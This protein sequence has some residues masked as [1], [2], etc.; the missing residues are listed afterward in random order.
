MHRDTH[1]HEAGHDHDHD[2]CHDHC[3]GHHGEEGGHHHHGGVPEPRRGSRGI[4]L[5][6]FG[7][8]LP[9]AHAHY[10]L[11][12]AEVRERYPDTEVRWAFTANRIR[13][14]LRDR[15]IKRLSV[16]EA[17]SRMIDDGF[18]H[19]AV[20]SLHTLPSVEYE[21]TVRQAEAMRHPRKGLTGISVGAPLLHSMDDLKRAA[22]V[23]GESLLPECGPKDGV[24]LVGHGTY[25]QGQA[26]YLALESLL[27]QDFQ[28]VA[29]G[30]LMDG[31]QAAELGGR[32]L[33]KGVKRVFLVPF[34]CVPGHHV[35]V[36][37]FGDH[38]HSW[39]SVLAA[40]GLEVS[41]VRTG[42]LEHR[43][44]RAMWHDHLA[45]ALDALDR[46]ES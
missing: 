37:L 43:G 16:A 40:T 29:M 13:A 33:E 3:H 45:E 28:K 24:I 19:V 35:R 6:A 8:A 34:L 11:F 38:D 1:H 12:E 31:A 2:H 26:L 21:W 14:K 27:L 18:S 46:A 17:L 4:L 10:D 25:H 42:S 23:I 5:S 36:D 22:R 20:Q 30:T 15:G 32:F 7:C 39:K 9:E 41:T 44:F